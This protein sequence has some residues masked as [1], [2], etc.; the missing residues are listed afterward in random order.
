MGLAADDRAV[1]GGSENVGEEH[2]VVDRVA[3]ARA[4]QRNHHR[5]DE[6]DRPE[7]DPTRPRRGF[8]RRHRR[9]EQ[10]RICPEVRPVRVL[11]QAEKRE[12]RAIQDHRAGLVWIAREHGRRE[13]D[14]HDEQE[15]EQI[16]KQQRTVDV[17]DRCEAPDRTEP[18]G[19]EDGEREREAEEAR[20]QCREPRNEVPSG[21]HVR[22]VKLEHE[23]S[24]RD[25]EHSIG[26]R[27]KPAHR[28]TA[29]VT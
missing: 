15:R 8:T 7:Q 11:R 22:H 20:D 6:P 18:V 12:M 21:S 1:A 19:A 14:E 24:H 3:R 5:G 16:E 13:R 9:L 25:G 4:D 23:E 27:V 10:L 17:P 2:D 26:E 28:D 29:E